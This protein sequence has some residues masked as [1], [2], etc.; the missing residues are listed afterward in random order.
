MRFELKREL[1]RKTLHI[2][3]LI[4]PWLYPKFSIATLALLFIVSGL[5]LWSEI[6][7]IRGRSLPLLGPWV[8]SRV[9][10]EKID[11]AP[12]HRARLHFI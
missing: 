7:R 5:Y 11:W 6:L 3:A 4:I 8:R 12:L 10:S 1:K 9:R 2:P